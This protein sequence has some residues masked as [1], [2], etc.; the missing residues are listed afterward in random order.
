MQD[1]RRN[2]RIRWHHDDVRICPATV[3]K[4]LHIF[5][6]DVDYQRGVLTADLPLRKVADK[7]KQEALNLR[8]NELVVVVNVQVVVATRDHG[9]ESQHSKD[10]KQLYAVV[11]VALLRRQ[12][13]NDELENIDTED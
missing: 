9:C 4:A 7:L 2:H 1:E 6:N 11:L 5:A 8:Y 12:V 13:V 3:L 10:A